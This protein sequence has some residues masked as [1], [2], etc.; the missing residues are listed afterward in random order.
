[1]GSMKGFAW[2]CGGLRRST[3][4]TYSKVMFFEKSFKN[5]FDFF[6]FLETHHKD[7]NDL[8][9]EL[10]RYSDTH[11]IIHSETEEHD[12]HTGIIGLIR[13]DYT[14]SDIEHLI[15]G[16]IL[17][18]KL[19]N[20]TSKITHRI[21]VVYLP[22]NKNIEIEGMQQILRKLRFN[23]HTNN[24]NDMILGDFNFIDHSKDKKNGL[25]SKDREINKVWIPFL[26]E[27]DLVDPFREQNPNRKIWSF[28]GTGVAGNS[29]IDRV[30]VNS[31]NMTNITNMKYIQTPFHGH[32]VLVFCIKNDSEWGKGYYK[33]NTSLFEDDEYENIVK[34]TLAEIET[35]TNRSARDKWEVFMM[36]M[37]TKSMRY[38]T[39]RNSTKKRL[40]SELI[41]QMN[42][43]E[44]RDDQ[45][46]FGEQYAYLKG[47]LKQ[48]EDKEIDGYIRRVRFLVPYEKSEPDIAF[49]SKVEG[50]KRAKDRINQ[51]AETR[52][53]EIFT[54]NENIMRI[55]TKFYKD[56]YTTDKV[57]EKLQDKLL[58]N[59][60]TKLSE[61]A[62]TDLDKPFTA[63]EV[64]KAINK[65][66]SGKSPGLDGFPIEFYKEYWHLIEGLFMAYVSEVL[67]VGIS[68]SRNVSVIK[69]IYK[70]T[71]EIFLLTNFRPI[72]LINADVKIITKVLTERLKYVLPSIIHSTQTAV[73]GR[74]IDQNIHLVRDLIDLAN[75]N[76]ETAAFLFLDQ[77]KAFDR[78]NHKFLFKTME[79]FGIGQNFIK[80]VST[81]YTNASSVLH[82]NGHF[83]EK[84]TF[85]KRSKAR[86]PSKRFALCPRY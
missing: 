64:F 40:K 29:R 76:D 13:N 7:E 23:D 86:L 52:D 72:S 24:Y 12:T 49:F 31:I 9:N 47:R 3:A 67:E 73:Y 5:D 70:K 45:E 51:L 27:M 36:T 68:N 55:S 18:L 59:V 56:L 42:I 74:K 11:H 6:F 2:N 83:S 19:T 28:I 63:E 62:K 38:S 26:E 82:I 84:N 30:Y 81:I 22:T 16:R 46:N 69:L 85:Q 17:R 79:A 21:S 60:K 58:R 44:E 37:K 34:E 32:K 66:Q 4:S 10:L 35:L 15:Q 33:L 39:I 53:G 48:I 54:D 78:V 57:N 41:K 65:L 43:I 14:I 75:K 20:T 61:K 80:W 50:Q 25:N 77:E 71:G 8:P 1:M